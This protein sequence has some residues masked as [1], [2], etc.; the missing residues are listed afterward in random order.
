MKGELDSTACCVLDVVVNFIGAVVVE[1]GRVPTWLFLDQPTINMA[2]G[3]AAIFFFVGM[4]P[5]SICSDQ[6]QTTT[7]LPILFHL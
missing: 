3:L 2:V 1:I 5:A 6:S 7:L 4:V